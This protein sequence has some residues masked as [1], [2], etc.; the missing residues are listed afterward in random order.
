MKTIF[1]AALYGVVLSF[2]YHVSHVIYSMVT[3]KGYTEWREADRA[4]VAKTAIEYDRLQRGC[5]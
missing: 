4:M 1:K 3:L 2:A 5:K